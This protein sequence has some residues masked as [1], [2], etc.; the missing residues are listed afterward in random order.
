MNQSLSISQRGSLSEI[1]LPPETVRGGESDLQLV[2]PPKPQKQTKTTPSNPLKKAPAS[3]KTKDLT[4][5]S[6][7]Q[8]RLQ[9]TLDARAAKKTRFENPPPGEESTVSKEKG[10]E[11]LTRGQKFLK[12][13]K[14]V[15]KNLGKLTKATGDGVKYVSGGSMDVSKVTGGI[16][17]GTQLFETASD[18]YLA[19]VKVD[20]AKS[21]LEVVKQFS[22]EKV[23]Q[24][25][26]HITGLRNKA[27]G[28]KGK[29]ETGISQTTKQ[30]ST[31][32][33]K[34]ANCNSTI[35]KKEGEMEA[36]SRKLDI[37]KDNVSLLRDNDCGTDFIQEERS[38]LR[39]QLKDLETDISTLEGRRD[40]LERILDGKEKKLGKLTVLLP[41]VQTDLDELNEMLTK[42]VS[43]SRL[44][45]RM[46]EKD[47]NSY[48]DS[49]PLERAKLIKSLWDGQKAITDLGSIASV[50][51]SVA[52]EGFKLASGVTG[53][54]VGPLTVAV[55]SYEF[56]N[57][58]K[59]NRAFLGL[60]KKST[61]ALGRNDVIKQDDGEL[62]AIAERLR[63]KQKKQSVDKGLSATKNFFGALGGVGTATAGAVAIAV[64]A[65]AVSATATGVLIATPVGWGLAGLAALAAIGYGVYKLARHLNSKGIKDALQTTISTAHSNLPSAKVGELNLEG[66]EAKAM[67]KVTDKMVAALK[68]QGITATAS[69][70][71]M[72]EV[73]NYAAKKLLARDTGV[74]TAS[75]YHRFKDEAALHFQQQGIDSPTEKDFDEYLVAK[76]SELPVSSAVGL[77]STLG[78]SLS[79]GEALDL[80]RDKSSSDGVK[81]LSKKLKLA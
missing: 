3:Y 55:N 6:K 30:I 14:S 58:V 62:L 60:K 79:K 19:K 52:A 41:K 68:S 56:Y 51:G 37:L 74:A 21:D 73:E 2:D 28:L 11:R 4:I 17:A 53:V 45:G 5:S 23:K 50:S 1:S 80:F 12:E 65:G 44:K 75:L 46:A 16:G 25:E 57:D 18:I 59:E 8:E 20:K 22:P 78:L 63:L 76:K 48:N 66:K 9:K 70:F 31:L 42:H 49:V 77:M 64:T 47:L 72:V 13:F 7:G 10:K 69:D 24:E 32:K 15:F 39:G 38:R 26:E 34:I 36:I 81:F 35:L 29:T 27:A 67:K 40:K 71:T 54:V 61:E 43:T 33:S